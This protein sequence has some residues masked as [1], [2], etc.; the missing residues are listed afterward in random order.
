MRAWGLGPDGFKCPCP[1]AG[2]TSSNSIEEEFVFSL[3][4]VAACLFLKKFTLLGSVN[5]AWVFW[6]FKVNAPDRMRTWGLGV[7][8]NPRIARNP[9]RGAP[10]CVPTPPR[11]RGDFKTH[12]APARRLGGRVI[13][14]APRVDPPRGRGDCTSSCGGRGFGFY[15]HRT[16]CL[17]V[18]SYAQSL[19]R[20]PVLCA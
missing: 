16:T 14:P 19:R 8:R 5:C 2:S 1:R 11:G 6:G 4:D 10:P 9:A 3:A 18:G 12:R 7:R 17:S 20:A 15:A 13:P